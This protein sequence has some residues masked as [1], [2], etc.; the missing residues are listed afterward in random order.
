[1]LVPLADQDAEPFEGLASVQ[2]AVR[3]GMVL[4]EPAA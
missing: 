2:V 4:R 1:M 3:P